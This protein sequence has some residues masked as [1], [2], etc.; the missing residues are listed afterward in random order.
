MDDA[1][2]WADDYNA[3]PQ[4]QP[5]FWLE[6]PQVTRVRIL[7]GRG[8]ETDLRLALK[9]L[10]A[11]DEIVN[12]TYNTRFKIKVLALRALALDAQGNALRPIG[13]SQ[14]IELSQPGG[15]IRVYIDLGAPMQAMLS[16]LAGQSLVVGW[17]PPGAQGP[18]AGA[19]GSLLL[20]RRALLL[21]RRAPLRGP[22]TASWQPSPV[23]GTGSRL[24]MTNSK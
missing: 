11:L 2:R 20:E 4:D 5:L 12:R 23:L 22:F 13:I 9:I 18:T 6:E 3:L 19:Q 7:V 8:S 17:G 1:G 16:R 21:E 10:E 15:F 14:S 24:A